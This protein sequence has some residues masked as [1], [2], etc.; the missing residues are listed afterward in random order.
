MHQ[1]LVRDKAA[2]TGASAEPPSRPQESI[3][4]KEQ[5]NKPFPTS[6]GSHTLKWPRAI[7][8]RLRTTSDM[9]VNILWLELVL[10]KVL[11]NLTR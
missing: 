6:Q 8:G 2:A 11:I 7:S 4:L 1:P 3:P 5:K 10:L 9:N